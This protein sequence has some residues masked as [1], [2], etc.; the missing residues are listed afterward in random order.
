MIYNYGFSIIGKSHIAANSCCQDS[1]A[2]K[3]LENGWVVAAVADGVGSA[4]NSQIGSKIAA[5][6][7]VDFCA[8]CMPSDYSTISIKSMLRTAYN[9]ALKQ[10]IK[11]SEKTGEP[12]ESYD[13]TLT[14]VIYDGHRI[15]YGH[16]GDGAIIG[17]TVFGDYIKITT[18]QKGEDLV[19]VVPLRAGYTAWVIDSYEEE[20][21]SVMLIT[22]GML[23]FAL[24]PYL[25][26]QSDSY[27]VYIPM[28]SFF[29]DPLGVPKNKKNWNLEINEIKDFLKAEDSY[30]FSRFY[31]RLEKIYK[32]RMKKESVEVLEK[33]NETNYA[34][35]FMKS[36]ED[37]K[38]LVALINPELT[39]DSKD[40]DYYSEPNWSD[41][42]D[43]WNRKAYPHLYKNNEDVDSVFQEEPEKDNEKEQTN[44]PRLATQDT[45]VS[46]SVPVPNVTNNDI[47]EKVLPL[48]EDDSSIKEELLDLTVETSDTD[49]HK[50]RKKKK[51]FGIGQD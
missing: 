3:E 23:E 50:K 42:Q 44:D 4:K 15:I 34:I 41:L 38:T 20:L 35:A 19:S 39:V 11:E 28:A 26:R 37:D 14:T 24:C 49:S 36:V 48:N 8:E 46:E 40:K 7:V 27:E 22:D 12:L 16:S 47:E 21:A 51:W 9:Y 31:A 30:D 13:T 32:K 1:H 45:D 17:L 29:A 43:K 33:L 5:Q 25:L 18:P 2:L 10:I 6:T